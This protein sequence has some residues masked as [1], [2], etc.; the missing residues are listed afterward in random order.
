MEKTA[1]H[2]SM[3]PSTVESFTNVV[4]QK[5]KV[6]TSSPAK[7][8]ATPIIPVGINVTME[9]T[10]DHESMEPSTVESVDEQPLKLALRKKQLKEIPQM[11]PKQTRSKTKQKEPMQT[12]TTSSKTKA[13]EAEVAKSEGSSKLQTQA[14]AAE[15]VDHPFW[16][17]VMKM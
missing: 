13:N 7:K 2:E 6:K 11:S 14:E 3:E 5:K 8:A 15:P 4:K 10:A 17:D 12:V 16:L 1:D 9:R